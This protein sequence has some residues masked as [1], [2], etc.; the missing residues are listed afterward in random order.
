MK[1]YIA[2]KHPQVV[3]TTL[4]LLSL[5]TISLSIASGNPTPPNIVIIYADDLGFGD[6]GCYNS[7][8]RIPTP[9]LDRLAGSGLLFTN[10]HS[11]DTI[12]SPSRYGIL[13][14]RYFGR[15]VGV[16]QNNPLPGAQ[17]EIDP[18]RMTL[19][20]MLRDAG[21]DTAAIGKWGLG[22]DWAA[23][24]KPGRKGYDPTPTAI[25]YSKAIFAGKPFGF[26]YEA[27]HY[28]YGY[29]YYEGTDYDGD[30][31]HPFTDGGRWHFENGIARNGGPNFSE[32]D[33]VQA[34]LDYL[35]NTVD[36]IDSKKASEQ[37]EARFN[38]QSDA[39]FFIYYAPH[40]P[41]LPL[42][43]SP[44]F[45]GKS[46][47]GLY[48]DF[49]YQLDWSVGEIID[50]LSRNGLRENTL[51][52]FASDNGP[53]R[54]A[55]PRISKYAH[56]SMGTWRGLKRDLWEGGHRTPFIVSWPGQIEPGATEELISQVD[57]F[58]TIA[59]ILEQALPN[60]AAE[61]SISF[62][63]VLQGKGGQREDIL[64]RSASG[65][66]LISRG[67]WTYM[68]GVGN[69]TPELDWFREMRSAAFPA[70][71][72]ELFNLA[73]DPQQIHNLIKKEPSKAKELKT[74]LQKQV[75]NGRS[76]PHR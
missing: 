26:T 2:Y 9:N 27:L 14:G 34:Q 39:P 46:E 74:L 72:G 24:A 51:V 37:S 21:Y 68:N 28:W 35:K 66:L 70:P 73:D 54:V 63:P 75:E 49:V 15:R 6:L 29:E 12:C 52:I 40:I 42:A 8:S 57:V 69:S 10:A 13:T 23:A 32:F 64:C 3:K 38:Q 25:D 20:S 56:F 44:Q 17:P 67:E 33:M 7:G 61:D 48:G 50:A 65:N 36:Y 71:E 1:R 45:I 16:E 58:A 62:L 59:E 11:P 30:F 4:I 31:Q 18:E 76:A 22:A 47:A 43:V 53:E 5:F 19:P 41:H 60:E 55:Y